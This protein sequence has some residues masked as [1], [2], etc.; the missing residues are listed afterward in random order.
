VTPAGGS[1]TFEVDLAAIAD[2]RTSD[3]PIA[4]G[5]VVHVPASVARI[6]PWSVWTVA[7]E[8]IHVGGSV[9]LF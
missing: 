7:K 1:R 6:V 8:M 4:D 9:L 2:G 5:D 3:V